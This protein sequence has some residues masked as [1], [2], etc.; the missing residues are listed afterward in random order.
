M[1]DIYYYYEIFKDLWKFFKAHSTPVP[2]DEWWAATIRD[3]D[4]MSKRYGDSR[5][6]VRMIAATLEEIS[7]TGNK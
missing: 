4:A 6:V 3:A 2:S 7:C 5:F 1:R